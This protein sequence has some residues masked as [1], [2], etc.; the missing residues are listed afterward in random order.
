MAST[1]PDKIKIKFDARMISSSGIGTQVQNVLRLLSKRPDIELHLVGDPRD[2]YRHLPGFG[3]RITEFK[4]PIYSIG[5]QLFFPAPD[6]DELLHIPHYNAPIRLLRKSVIVLH[7][8]IHLQSTQFARPHYRIYTYLLLFFVS[9]FARRV[10]TVSDTTRR[11]FLSRFPK[12]A[13]RT[14]LVYN[15]I[16]HRLLKPP[17]DKDIKTFR[18]EYNL[19]ARFLLVIGIGKRH[20][21][22]DFAIH[23]SGSTCCPVASRNGKDG[24][25]ASSHLSSSSMVPGIEK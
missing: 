24:R 5:E 4:Q 20:K 21:N 25:E 8:L 16:D 7:D 13:A 10:A 6:A 3:G 22:V 17:A 19:P 1:Q 23:A 11:E 14:S 15:G 18:K 9:R 12:A 2:I